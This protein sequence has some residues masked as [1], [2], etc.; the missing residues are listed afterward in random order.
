MARL[1]WAKAQR[2]HVKAQ[3]ALLGPRV[4]PKAHERVTSKRA[5]RRYESRQEALRREFLAREA[6]RR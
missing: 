3:V 5:A 1:N 4:T 6:L 2:A